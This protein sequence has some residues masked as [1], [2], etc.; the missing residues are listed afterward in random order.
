MTPPTTL[1]S[2]AA[3][4]T[5]PT[6]GPTAPAA[7]RVLREELLRAV[8]ADA[9]WG[10]ATGVLLLAVDGTAADDDCTVA[11]AQRLRTAVRSRD[12]WLSLGERSHALVLVDLPPALA[13]A[14][15]DRAADALLHALESAE[16]TTP[17]CTGL[18]VSVGAGLATGGT[19]DA[20]DLLDLALD[21][22]AAARAAGGHCARLRTA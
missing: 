1:L 6:T 3:P 7:H 10:T 8:D 2:P 13:E 9:R 21:A 15:V 16:R 12:R 22:L 19:C 11:V 17:R 18:R 20:D 14:S 4:P 5:A